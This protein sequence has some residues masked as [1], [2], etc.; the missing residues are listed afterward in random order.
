MS[1]ET[2]VIT[3]HINVKPSIHVLR[4]RCVRHRRW[5]DADLART[6]EPARNGPEDQNRRKGNQS[7]HDQQQ[8]QP[9]QQA[10]D[11]QPD[12]FWEQLEEIARHTP[13]PSERLAQLPP[14]PN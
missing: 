7:G 5:M 8:E 13:P 2:D 10:A 6:P 12:Q 14:P 9:Q 4:T 11:A 3:K 1:Y